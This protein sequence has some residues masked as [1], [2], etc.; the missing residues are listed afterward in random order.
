MRFRAWSALGL[1]GFGS[2]LPLLLTDSTLKLW[3]RSLHVDIATIGFFALVQLPYNLK[4]LWAP[5]LD[6]FTPPL[7]G[8][9]RGWLILTQALLATTLLW[10]A[11]GDPHGH[12]K[13][14]AGLAVGLAFMSASQDTVTDAW[15]TEVLPQDRQALGTAV[16]VS[17]YRVAMVVATTGAVLIA[18]EYGWR[19]AYLA[20]AELMLLGLVGTLLAEEP[21]LDRP[22]RTLREAVVE[23][24]RAFLQRRGIWL[25]LAFVILYKLGD[26]LATSLTGP[27][28]LDTGFSLAAIGLMS[29]GV[30]IP[31][32][33]LGGFLSGWWMKKWPLRHGLM[34]CGLFQIAST[35]SLL[36][37]AFFGAKLPVLALSI[38]LENIGYGMGVTVFMTLMM[39]LC[40]RHYTATQFA[41]LTSL[42]ALSRSLLAAPAGVVVKHTGWP[43]FFSICGIT[44][45]PGL[46]MLLWWD[47]W[48]VPEDTAT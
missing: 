11:F 19:A 3:L 42:G 25:A 40:D 46:L 5:F 1:L 44:A 17:V 38:A 35:L 29:K 20:M 47:R 24:F 13:L 10:M 16:H 6:R 43:V 41:L 9:R 33:I 32:L 37:P 8:R 31:G 4:F 18:A 39:R 14:L 15:R 45:I 26:Q 21:E 28:F 12:L 7:F 27:Y 22:P 2:G 23:P 36:L 34:V 30:G 48:G